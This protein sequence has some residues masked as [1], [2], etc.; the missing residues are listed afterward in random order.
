MPWLSSRWRILLRRRTTQFLILGGLEEAEPEPDPEVVV[1]EV[2][3]E[4]EEEENLER[5]KSSV[6]SYSNLRFCWLAGNVKSKLSPATR[7]EKRGTNTCR[8]HILFP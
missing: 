6:K 4:E 5:R 7:S 8:P 3:V 2:E 1:V